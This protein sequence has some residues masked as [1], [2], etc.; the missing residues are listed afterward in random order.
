MRGLTEV[1][2]VLSEFSEADG[3]VSVHDASDLDVASDGRVP[4][5]LDDLLLL[6]YI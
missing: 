1:F 3:A 2:V 4:S 6:V 5:E